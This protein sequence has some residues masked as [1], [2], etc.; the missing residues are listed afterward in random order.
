MTLAGIRQSGLYAHVIRPLLW[1]PIFA[2]RWLRDTRRTRL[3]EKLAVE[4]VRLLT[5]VR[6]QDRHKYIGEV[7]PLVSI[8]TPTYNRGQLVA[9]ST[10]PAVLAQSY[11]N[12]EWLIVGDHCTDDTAARLAQVHDP[13]VHFQNLPVRP[14]YPRNKAKRWKIVG[15]QA[16]NLAHQLAKGTWI[17]HLDDDDV[18][19]PDH[20]AKLLAHAMAGN[21]EFVSGRCRIERRKG[22]W[23]VAGTSL[24][25]DE[26]KLGH[27][28]HSTI[29][30]RS[31]LDKCFPY[32]PE[33]LKV[34]MAGD[35][36]RWRRM[37]NAGVRI[38]FIPDIVTYQPLRPRESERSLDHFAS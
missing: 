19:A 8:T 22:E 21:Y 12:F 33:C 6:A 32:D 35:T 29:L 25:A 4:D 20:I 7:S 10:L 26:A 11:P 9:E 24:I 27:V 37:L 34:N 16:N 31:Y 15:Y 17:A 3:F 28:S 13:R 18:F 1:G 14:R 2:H 36:Y 38:G 23:I 5:Q 30:Y